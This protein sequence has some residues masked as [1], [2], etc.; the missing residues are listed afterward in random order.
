MAVVLSCSLPELDGTD[1]TC[2]CATG[3]VCDE[4]LDRCVTADASRVDGG[5][6]DAPIDDG[7]EDARDA[8]PDAADAM[9]DVGSDAP[10]LDAPAVDGG[11]GCPHG[12][13]Y[14]INFDSD[15]E[16]YD[17][18]GTDLFELRSPGF[19]SAGTGYFRSTGDDAVVELQNIELPDTFHARLYIRVDMGS[20]ISAQPTLIA[21][22]F[23]SGGD[24]GAGLSIQNEV[25]TIGIAFT[26]ASGDGVFSS[27]SPVTDWVCVRMEASRTQLRMTL[28]DAMT[29]SAP[30]MLPPDDWDD[31]LFGVVDGDHLMGS[32]LSI[33][34]IVVGAT[35]I[36]CEL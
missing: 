10:A 28:D 18:G 3:F 19:M 25:G 36:P 1:K 35:P 8:S 17:V 7:G 9:V 12:G 2:P 23:Q 13:L 14:C 27:Y 21:G 26:N 32:G 31:L 30:I 15:D 5:E 33:D 20:F 6:P 24:D 34:E 11:T 22:F 4:L 29:M 16:E